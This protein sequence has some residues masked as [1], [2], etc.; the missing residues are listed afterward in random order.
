[1]VPSYRAM[2]EREGVDNPVSLALLGDEHYLRR[3]LARYQ[4]LGVSDFSA[5]L[6]QVDDDAVDR[7]LEFLATLT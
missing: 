2:L 4:D 7:T 5:S 6:L 1:M 3:E